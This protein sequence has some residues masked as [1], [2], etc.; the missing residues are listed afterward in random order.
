MEV[1]NE[2]AKVKDEVFSSGPSVTTLSTKINLLAT[3]LAICEEW[4]LSID[5]KVPNRSTTKWRK[6]CSLY[7]DKNTGQLNQRI[8]AVSIRPYQSSIILM[9][10][11]DM[12]TNQRHTYNVTK[13]V[14]A[15]NWINLK[16]SQMNGRQEIKV[17]YELVYSKTNSVPKTWTSLNLVTGT[18]NGGEN[19]SASVQYRNFEINTCKTKGKSIR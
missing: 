5:V 13:K 7:V 19:I 12:R 1:K 15:D 14:S 3:D 4:S 16:I 6:I 2:T 18:T 11:Y 9:I 8:L 10:A 17:D